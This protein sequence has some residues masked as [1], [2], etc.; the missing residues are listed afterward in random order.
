[1]RRLKSLLLFIRSVRGRQYRTASR[2]TVASAITLQI[3]SYG[4]WV[5]SVCVPLKQ[6]EWLSVPSFVRGH[7]VGQSSRDLNPEIPEYEQASCSV[8]RSASPLLVM[9]QLSALELHLQ[10]KLY[11]SLP[12]WMIFALQSEWILLGRDWGDSDEMGLTVKEQNNRKGT[13]IDVAFD[14]ICWRLKLLWQVS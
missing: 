3:F 2:F 9:S 5:A 10:Y 11:C 6:N 13:L 14:I 4:A 8:T 1:M 12:T 7:S